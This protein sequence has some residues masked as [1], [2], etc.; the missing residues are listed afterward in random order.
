MFCASIGSFARSAEI[1]VD[2]G[3]RIG[4]LLDS[5]SEIHIGQSSL[6][7]YQFH[8]GKEAKHPFMSLLGRSV[9]SSPMSHPVASYNP[10]CLLLM[11]CNGS[12]ADRIRRPG[13]GWMKNNPS[14]AA[15]MLSKCI[16]VEV[17]KV[18]VLVQWSQCIH[19]ESWCLPK[20]ISRNSIVSSIYYRLPVQN[21]GVNH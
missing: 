8:F 7:N 17:V 16:L 6:E 12:P 20:Q 2:K 21:Q 14:L 13:I 19:N 18:H 11:K 5:D 4:P 9:T 15:D 3:K 1:N 10:S